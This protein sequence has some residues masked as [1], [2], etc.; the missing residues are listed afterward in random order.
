M[1]WGLDII[2]KDIFDK[3][4]RLNGTSGHYTYTK[5]DRSCCFM[6]HDVP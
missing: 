6:I 4:F 2:Y 5:E 3:I 1:S